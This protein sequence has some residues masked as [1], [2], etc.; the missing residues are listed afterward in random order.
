MDV[1]LA[2]GAGIV[3]HYIKFLPL[4]RPEKVNKKS[5]GGLWPHRLTGLSQLHKLTTD[6]GILHTCLGLAWLGL[7]PNL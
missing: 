2:G 4:S 7:G 5:R 6:I 1:S 3:S